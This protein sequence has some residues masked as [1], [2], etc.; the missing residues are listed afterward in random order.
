MNDFTK[1]ELKKI[2]K[3]YESDPY[4][5]DIQQ[6]I[7]NFGGRIQ[8]MIDNYGR[9]RVMVRGTERYVDEFCGE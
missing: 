9:E 2:L 6:R 7:V 8:S 1:E 4:Y 3:A 5:F